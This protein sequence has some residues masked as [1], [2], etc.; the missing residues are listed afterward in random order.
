MPPIDH[1]VVQAQSLKDLA[2]AYSGSPSDI[3]TDFAKTNNI[4]V[5]A[6]LRVGQELK[7]PLDSAGTAPPGT[8]NDG[9]ACVQ[10]AVPDNVYKSI[11]GVSTPEATVTPPAT[12]SKDVQ[13]DS[14]SNDWTVI[15]DGTSQP[16]NQGVVSVAKGTA[17][18]FV[19]K[20]GLHT[21]TINGKKDGDN[22]KQG[23]TRT[24]TFNDAG[25]FKIT[26]DFHPAMLADV[27]VQ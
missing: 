26:C 12:A 2:K 7:V 18:E 11:P 9:A 19:N 16:A 3:A 14:H 24:I 21:I 5:D 15:A 10:Y 4:P 8:I 13:I 1:F 6:I 25:Q 22:F 20:E 23:E 27:F 17:V